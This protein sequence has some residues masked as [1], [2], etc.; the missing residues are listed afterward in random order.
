MIPLLICSVSLQRLSFTN[1]TIL[2]HS[3]NSLPPN[4]HS[5]SHQ[6]IGVG[7]VL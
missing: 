4:P 3:N 5:W 1:M 7:I 2:S 6:P